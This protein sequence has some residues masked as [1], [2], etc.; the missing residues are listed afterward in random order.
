MLVIKTTIRG[1]GLQQFIDC[2][3]MGIVIRAGKQNGKPG[4]RITLSGSRLHELMTKLWPY[5]PISRKLEYAELRRA[6]KRWK[7]AQ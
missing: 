3:D 6:A 4:E 2:V 5:L 7:P 1:E